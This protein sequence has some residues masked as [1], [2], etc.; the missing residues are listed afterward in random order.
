MKFST[1]LLSRYISM[2]DMHIAAEHLTRSVCEVEEVI[3]RTLPDLLVVWK[4]LSIEKHPDADK[5]VVCQIDCGSHGHFQICTAAT[6]VIQN[7]L[8][9]VS[10]PWCYLEA[11]DLKIWARKMRWLDSNGMIC[12][13][14]ELW[15]LED[16]ELHGIWIMTD[17]LEFSDTDIW[18]SLKEVCPWLESTCI[19][20]DNK[21]LT[22]RPDLTWHLWIARELYA[23]SH[24][25]DDLSYSF[26]TIPEKNNNINI[27]E[28]LSHT[29]QTKK[30]VD[31]QTKHVST[32]ITV[33]LENITI[34]KSSFSTRVSLLELD[35]Q[36]K[37]NRVDI[38]NLFMISTDQPI[39]FF[40]ADMIKGN[41]TV[42]QA[43]E[44]ETCLL[45]TDKKAILTPDDIVIA[46][47]EKI[48]AIAWV[49]WCKESAVSNTTTNIIAEI[50][51]FDP[52]LVR[53]TALRLDNRTQAS[54]RFEKAPNPARAA[55]ALPELLDFLKEYG[56]T[57]TV[58]WV[59]SYLSP[60]SQ[61]NLWK[62]QVIIDEQHLST[63]LWKE[64]DRKT[65]LSLLWRWV[66]E[67]TIT[68][69]SWRSYSDISHSYD[70]YEEV[71]R[72]HGFD[73][74]A[75]IYPA[76]KKPTPLMPLVTLRQNIEHT[77]VRDCQY[78]HEETYPRVASD[79]NFS[80]LNPAQPDKPFLRAS[81]LSPLL[82]VLKKNEWLTQT[83]R[84]FDIG[85]TW[86]NNESTDR[87]W[88]HGGEELT[89][90]CIIQSSEKNA[91]QE[92]SF[93]QVKKTLD[94]VAL[95]VLNTDFSYTQATDET[96][97]SHPQQY[98]HIF[99]KETKVGYIMTLSPLS[100][101][102]WWQEI[103]YAQLSLP[104]LLDCKKTET[105]QFDTL[106]DQIIWRDLNFVVASDKSFDTIK[107]A[108]MTVSEV[109]GIHLFDIY[110]IDETKT[111]YALSFRLTGDGSLTTQEI[112]NI[113]DKCIAAAEHAGARLRD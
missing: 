95:R 72:L 66:Q 52:L 7:A 2:K 102:F 19:D 90:W 26:T 14:E 67:T 77:L 103:T 78:I 94:T 8:V 11:I 32:Y 28:M 59:S 20:V 113:M 31:I 6:N 55:L 87:F 33:E 47:D 9:P 50:A 61:E 38:S 36:P 101:D 58:T 74:F 81:L 62:K 42:R 25:R 4:V 5:L 49:M 29:K 73:N 105:T 22:H 91:W 56:L 88:P 23:L 44:W 39:H 63:F 27:Q 93:V 100:H 57:Y 107:S 1:T 86:K 83:K 21:T 3:T 48:L 35:Q 108:L 69:P 18:K 97:L 40:D 15:I 51:S 76:A 13:K 24:L 53:K 16:T 92:R 98:A 12:A 99:Y 34:K 17:D 111:S 71:A 68:I 106:Q 84:V 54:L 30:N 89:C 109:Q 10:L 96:W 70:I 60:L 112:N 65:S 43:K 46:D 82:D 104:S 41:I 80:F 79:T 45:L 64:F 85:S 37:N 75:S 110:Q